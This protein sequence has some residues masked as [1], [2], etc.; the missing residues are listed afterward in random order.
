MEEKLFRGELPIQS[1]Y[2]KGE[3]CIATVPVHLDVIA[4]SEKIRT[5]ITLIGD[6]RDNVKKWYDEDMGYYLNLLKADKVEIPW[7][8]GYERFGDEW[9]VG[10]KP[11]ENGFLTLFWKN[12]EETHNIKFN[13]N[14]VVLH[15]R[16]NEFGSFYTP[17]FCRANGWIEIMYRNITDPEVMLIEPEKMRRYGKETATNRIDIKKGVAEVVGNTFS[18]DYHMNMAKT[19]LLRD[20]AVFYLNRLLE[21]S[22]GSFH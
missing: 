17:E 7:L 2:Q 20:F 18:S 1:I 5:D 8:R 6:A 15:N 21:V 16:H 11:D 19:L 3:A 10:G 22:D 4:M 13:S 14:P 12:D 9:Q